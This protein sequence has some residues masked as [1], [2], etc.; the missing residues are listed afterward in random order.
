M[1]CLVAS[2]TVDASLSSS[3]ARLKTRLFFPEDKNTFTIWRTLQ[4]P[5]MRDQK[6]AQK[7]AKGE[8][9]YLKTQAPTDAQR[10]KL[11]VR[12]C[13]AARKLSIPG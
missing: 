11:A 10:G 4:F 12:E 7:C 8:E 13:T 2:R 3:Q 9:L 6:E 1:L 5:H